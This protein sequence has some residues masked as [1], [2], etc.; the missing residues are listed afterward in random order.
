MRGLALL[1][2]VC[3]QAGAVDTLWEVDLPATP[4]TLSLYSSEKPNVVMVG[5]DKTLYQLSAVGDVVWTHDFPVGIA[6]P[7]TV[8][9]LGGDA[10]D[11]IIVALQDGT[12]VVL[13]GSGVAQWQQSFNTRSGGYKHVIAADVH[14]SPGLEVIIGFDDGWLNCMSATGELLWRFYG[15]KF[16]VGISAVGDVDGDGHPEIVYGTD[17]GNIYCL[18]GYGQMQWRYSELAPY[19][20]SGVNLADL[21]GDGSVEVL[22]T[23]SNNGIATCLMALDGATGEYKWR[24][25]DVQQ[26]YVSNAI[27]DFEDDG[28]LEVIHADKGNWVYCVNSDGTERWRTSLAGRGIFWA[29]VVGDVDGDGQQE[30]LVTL[31][32][33]LARVSVFLLNDDGTIQEKVEIAGSANAGAVLGD[34]NGD[35]ILETVVSTS[36]PNRVSMLSWGGGGKVSW[37]GIRGNGA[38]TGATGVALGVPMRTKP[39]VIATGKGLDIEVVETNLGASSIR[40]KPPVQKDHFAV[41]EIHPRKGASEYR[42]YPATALQSQWALPFWVDVV[43]TTDVVVSLFHG[44]QDGRTPS[45]PMGSKHFRIKKNAVSLG[46][47]DKD[48][49]EARA[50]S[51]NEIENKG[52]NVGLLRM[53]LS[54]ILMEGTMLQGLMKQNQ[55]GLADRATRYREK[56]H[57]LEALI[58]LLQDQAQAGTFLWW[59]DTNPWDVFEVH[60][61]DDATNDDDAI[62]LTA[63]GDEREDIA[64]N[65]LNTTDHA[66][67]VRVGFHAPL[68][69]GG[70]P[71]AD[72]A[73]AKHITLRRAVQVPS[74]NRDKVADLLPEL[75]RTRLLTLAPG[76]VTQLWVVVDTHG[77]E[78]GTHDWKLYVGS[79]EQET[80]IREIPLKVEVLPIRLPEGIYAQMNWV[81]INRNETSDQQLDDMLTHGISVAYGPTLPSLLLDK[82]GQLAK[83][84]DWAVFDETLKRV[85]D[86]FQLLFHGPPAVQWPKGVT[87]PQDSPL[88]EQGFATAVKTMVKHMIAQG[89]G[90]ERWAYYPIDEPWLTGFTHVQHLKD[91]C[92]R[93]KRADSQARNYTNPAGNVR[94]EFLEPFK[95]LIDIWQPE[96]NLLKRDPK[97]HAWFKENAQTFWAYEATDPGKDLLPLGYYRGYAW[98]AWNFG[99][100]GAGF[101]VYKYHD[102]F[103]PLDTLHWSVVYPTDDE[104]TP[105][106][107]WEATRDGQEDYKVFYVLQQAI[108]TA[109]ADGR[110]AEADAAALVM[111]DALDEIIR[112]QVSTIDEI[113][114]QTRDSELDWERLQ[115]HRQQL[116]E[117]I[118][119][120]RQV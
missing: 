28:Q 1:L 6:T 4:G 67:T 38:M 19:G 116:A 31:R 45:R 23:R 74:Q 95:D 93:V 52:Y 118:L 92:E 2:L 120:L 91:F 44:A 97:L 11:E 109:R 21:D 13:D 16:H 90:Y 35:G 82:N 26:G 117:A 55:P 7:V 60:R 69:G 70:K 73:W 105:S 40:F 24:T 59:Q 114:R 39:S 76:E 101:W 22:I 30:V 88:Y 3:I 27:V 32:D 103:W 33:G 50:K 72:P 37:P 100:D 36:G 63:F 94:P 62:S 61:Y 102:I 96:M 5:A 87:A 107:R 12:V 106:R 78:A 43:E 84:P 99:L 14:I 104:V 8:A 65:L 47:P 58:T 71:P 15:D 68:L 41:V 25:E 9:D 51:I 86:Y 42:V 66:I 113:T 111:K 64:I 34:I 77:L 81:G 20:R 18:N 110:T 112:W 48:V 108:D 89:W 75:D 115:H 17:N 119:S 79:L 29:P 10:I 57:R 98:L 85:P 46:G 49:L 53:V 56:T 83:Q 54:D 80:T